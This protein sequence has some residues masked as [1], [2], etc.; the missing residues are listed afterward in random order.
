ML[1]NWIFAN[2]SRFWRIWL[3]VLSVALILAGLSAYFVDQKFAQYFGSP[4]MVQVW[5]FH[6]KITEIGAA[7]V[8]IIL[9]LVGLVWKKLR[10]KSAYLLACMLTSGIVVH[11]FKFLLGRQRPHKAPDNDPFIFDFF[12]VHH[13]W[14]SF[15][16]G[17]SQTLFSV[18]TVVAYVFPKS[19]PYIF[20][21]ALYL[22]FTRAVTLAHFV[23]DVWIGSAIGVL[24]SV[25]TLRILVRKYGP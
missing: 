2:T 10:R 12:N 19:A 23:S 20:T 17:H 3:V 11:L 13:H 1:N 5:L 16:S 7:E 14:Q 24:I 25:L 8:Y 6:R 21:L 4:E 18:A 22:A 9:G 15:P